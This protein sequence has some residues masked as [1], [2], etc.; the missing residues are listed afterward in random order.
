MD[1]DRLEIESALILKRIK[2][3]VKHLNFSGAAFSQFQRTKDNA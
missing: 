3:E 1:S 2:S